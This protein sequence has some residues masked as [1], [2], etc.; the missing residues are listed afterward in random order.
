[1]SLAL[2]DVRFAFTPSRP[3]LLNIVGRF[4]MRRIIVGC[5]AVMLAGAASARADPAPKDPR[6]VED[7]LAKWLAHAQEYGVKPA[8]VKYLATLTAYLAGQ[9]QPIVVHV[10]EFQM[11]DGSYGKGYVGPLTWAF[12]GSLPYDQLSNR[13]LVDVYTGWLW[14]FSALNKG[15]AKTDFQPTTREALLHSLAQKKIEMLKVT[16]QY[17][18]GD[19]EFYE[20]VG[21]GPNGPIK[22]A[23]STESQ[24][25]LDAASPEASLPLVYTYLAKVMKGEI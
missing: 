15:A 8:R 18:V 12:E 13:Q 21:Q 11:P 23:G 22:G 14:L 10:L 19:S 1:M 17:R 24:L 6:V 25:I 20:F 2:I 16:S 4:S 5:L 9:D 3:A 7:V